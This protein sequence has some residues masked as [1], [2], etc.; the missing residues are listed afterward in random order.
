MSRSSAPPIIFESG[1]TGTGLQDNPEGWRNPEINWFPGH[2]LKAVRELAGVLKRVDIVLELRDA[3][4]PLASVN[5]E[6]ETLL[7]QKKR[8]VLFNKT[9]L[10]DEE[11]TRDWKRHFQISGQPFLFIDVLEKSH[12]RKILPCA[13]DMMRSHWDRFR[14]RGIR[15]PPLKLMVVGIPNVG[16]S[17]LINRLTRRH[18][19]E[20]GPAPGLTRHQGWVLLG[21]NVELLDTPGIL[22]P[23]IESFETGIQLTLTGA[24]KDE[25]VGTQRL[26]D[27]LLEILKQLSFKKLVEVYR[28][29][30]MEP[31]IPSLALLDRI[32]RSRGYLKSGGVEDRI[33][34]AEQI[35]RDFRS[36]KLGRLSFERPR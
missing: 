12:L 34:A 9:G 26:A 5:P 14:G 2:M 20:T 31:G 4:I 13:R 27:Y 24:V 29:S 1:N 30:G 18:A 10:A 17:T 11:A 28:L 21:K 3:R 6:F 36:G 19:A 23:K 16:K 33:R 35:L 25:I 7:G 32:A 22:W 15:P 8:L